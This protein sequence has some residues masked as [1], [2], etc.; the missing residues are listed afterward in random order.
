MVPT[1]TT[2]R[3]RFLAESKEKKHAYRNVLPAAGIRDSPDA[4]GAGPVHAAA[5]Q[6][7]WRVD[8]AFSKTGG[9][10]R[11]NHEDHA[12]RNSCDGSLVSRRQDSAVVHAGRWP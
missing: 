4:P 2:T 6:G 9:G 5:A 3:L 10:S 12:C 8:H 1:G 7:H 11:A